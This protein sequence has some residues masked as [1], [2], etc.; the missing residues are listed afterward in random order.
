MQDFPGSIVEFVLDGVESSPGDQIEVC[1]LRKKSSDEAV[2]VF[3]CSSFPGRV[4]VS[5]IDH[6]ASLF[7]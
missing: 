2:G 4:W 1:F 3:V 5:K 6:H 7:G